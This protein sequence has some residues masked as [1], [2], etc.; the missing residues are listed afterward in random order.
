LLLAESGGPERHL[1]YGVTFRP[2]S[3]GNTGSIVV[4]TSSVITSVEQLRALEGS[5]LGYTAWLAVTQRDVSTF[6]EVTGDTYWIHTDPERAKDGPFGGTIAHGFFTLS[7]LVP[8]A[9]ALI[10][11]DLGGVGV[12]YGLERVRFPAPVPVGGRIR[13]GATLDSVTP[14][15]GGVQIKLVVSGEIEGVEK[16]CLVA[17]SLIRYYA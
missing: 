11:V 15:D 13:A 16:P 1:P 9:S 2:E 6:G 7:L 17:E 4:A 14:L 3:G 5:H 8:L 10:K 12:N